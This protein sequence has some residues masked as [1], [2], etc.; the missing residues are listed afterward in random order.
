MPF[1]LSDRSLKKLEG[2]NAMLTRCVQDA[3]LKTTVD[4]GVTEG[5]RSQQ[6]QQQLYDQKR[7]QTLLWKHIDGN[8]I[9]LVAYIGSE[10]CWEIGVYD[11]IADAMKAS[12]KA[13]GLPLRWG[14]GWH[15]N[16]TDHEGTAE[17]LMNEYIDLRR[18]QN[19]RP[20]IDCPHF[21]T[22]F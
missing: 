19:R 22:A 9:D 16:L 17:D 1:K 7:S 8:A 3:I 13:I 6:R 14:A 20:F 10:V 21:E 18:S 12:A 15:K 2:V 4:F 5:L 11:E